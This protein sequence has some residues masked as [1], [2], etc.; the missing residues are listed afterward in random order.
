MNT[1]NS[2]VPQLSLVGIILAPTIP[3]PTSAT[4]TGITHPGNWPVSAEFGVEYKLHDRQ[5]PQV[6]HEL[7][8]AYFDSVGELQSWL[9]EKRE[10][11]EGT[12]FDFSMDY[13]VYE[14]DWGPVF[15][16]QRSM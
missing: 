11:I 5:F 13:K 16:Y 15:K 9:E 2:A 10:W 14:W 12:D 8:V 4:F 3:A 1:I 7:T 6:K